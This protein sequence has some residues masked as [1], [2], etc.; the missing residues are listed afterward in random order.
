MRVFFAIVELIIECPQAGESILGD[1]DVGVVAECAIVIRVEFDLRV[2][3][4]IGFKEG[5][6]FVDIIIASDGTNEVFVEGNLGGGGVGVRG[7]KDA[8]Q[9][10]EVS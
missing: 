9:G 6:Q 8:E 3:I 10:R 4:H 5:C 2:G 1:E 7:G